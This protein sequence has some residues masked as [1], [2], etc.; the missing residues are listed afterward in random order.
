MTF[1]Y[2]HKYLTDIKTANYQMVAYDSVQYD[3]SGG[4]FTIDFPLAPTDGEVV[5]IKNTVFNDAP[6]TLVSVNNVETHIGLILNNFT[7][8][9]EEVYIE[10]A[11]DLDNAI[12]RLTSFTKAAFIPEIW[13]YQGIDLLLGTDTPIPLTFLTNF[14]PSPVFFQ[15]NAGNMECVRNFNGYFDLTGFFNFVAGANNQDGTVE[16]ELYSVAGTPVFLQGFGLVASSAVPR[17]GTFPEQRFLSAVVQCTV[18]DII[19]LQG[20][21]TGSMIVELVSPSGLYARAV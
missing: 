6:I 20:T 12:W 5:A 15:A 14:F 11:F 19:G 7:V 17:T 16:V 18:G 1:D 21:G 13:N 3:A 8:A 2:R 9:Q 4:T 10:W